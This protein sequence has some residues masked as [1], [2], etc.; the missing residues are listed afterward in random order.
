M[1]E[2]SDA[3]VASEQQADQVV[4]QS[5]TETD[6]QVAAEVAPKAG[7]ESM[8]S[9]NHGFMKN[10]EVAAALQKRIA[11]ESPEHDDEW[12]EAIFNTVRRFLFESEL[13]PPKQVLLDGL[14]QMLGDFFAKHD[15]PGPDLLVEPVMIKSLIFVAEGIYDLL[16][17]PP[18]DEGD[19]SADDSTTVEV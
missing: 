8:A 3:V 16:V 15:S 2:P 10:H 4:S 14:R 7:R 9:K 19:N 11:E 17:G 1:P 6:E 18:S 5:T 12:P 13:I